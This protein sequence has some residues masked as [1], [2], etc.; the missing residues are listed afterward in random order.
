M[1]YKYIPL[2]L[3]SESLALEND[4]ALTPPMGWL[5]WQTFQCN[6]E[7]KWKQNRLTS[8]LIKTMGDKIK[9]FG[10]D[11][12]GYRYVNLDDCWSSVKRTANGRLTVDEERFPSVEKGGVLID[13]VKALSDHL[14]S[15]GLKFGMYTDVGTA[16]CQRYPSLGPNFTNSDM[17]QFVNWDVDS[18]KVDGCNADISDMRR[19]YTEL[20]SVLK[21]QTRKILY[22]CSWPAYQ[23]SDHCENPSDMKAL[24]DNC[25][26]WRN[27]GDVQNDWSSVQAI[28]D[29]W[30]RGPSDIMVKAAGPGHWNDPDMLLIG[31]GFLTRPQERAQFALWAIF[32]APL[33]ISCDLRDISEISLEILKNRE[34]IAVN[35]DSLGSQGYV[36][37]SDDETRTWLRP[38]S[39]GR[40]AVLFQIRKSYLKIQR[41]ELPASDLG[42]TCFQA[43]DVHK[44]KTLPPSNTLE[45]RVGY[46]IVE[47]FVLTKS[48]R[49]DS[50][51]SGANH[52]T[53]ELG[54]GL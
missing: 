16:T 34:V 49:C 51:S 40:F 10:L 33:Y 45:V 13:G 35:Q 4:L 39:E 21:K 26:L 17:E 23:E 37:Q 18:L 25:N 53:V 2:A 31:N 48:E 29:F 14:H 52:L 42:W 32:A 20:S 6:V 28:V 54:S 7:R 44:H 3:L 11:E 9:Q 30:A 8:D 15:K 46:N 1:F 38:L 24:Q 47:M 36:F 27:Y 41:F 22:S 50:G 12:L 43:R 19:L 5:S